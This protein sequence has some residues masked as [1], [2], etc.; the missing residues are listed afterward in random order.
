MLVDRPNM[1]EQVLAKWSHVD[2][3]WL[4]HKQPFLL[5]NRKQ[6]RQKSP[7]EWQV[8]ARELFISKIQEQTRKHQSN[9]QDYEAQLK[10]VLMA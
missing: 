2:K 4:G 3:Q 7:N 5:R 1:L 8:T 10:C 6:Q 9:V